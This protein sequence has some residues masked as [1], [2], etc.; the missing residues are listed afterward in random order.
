MV[1]KMLKLLKIIFYLAVGV[2]ISLLLCTSLSNIYPN[3]N[4][5]GYQFRINDPLIVNKPDMLGSIDIDMNDIKINYT[6]EDN[7][8]TFVSFGSVKWPKI[9]IAS[10]GKKGIMD[11]T[12]SMFRYEN[13]GLSF[14]D[15]TNILFGGLEKERE[16]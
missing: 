8:D 6:D 1:G 12:G 15:A 7:T 2:S 16:L 11:F 13:M 9:I 10:N 5:F 4:L 14:K 3:F